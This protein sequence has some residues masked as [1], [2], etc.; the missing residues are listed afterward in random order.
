MEGK[1]NITTFSKFDKNEMKDFDHFYNHMSI[2]YKNDDDGDEFAES[3]MET[4]SE[5]FFYINVAIM[6]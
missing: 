6:E 5:N 4:T 1:L 2:M 3:T